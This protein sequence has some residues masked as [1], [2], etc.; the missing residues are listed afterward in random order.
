M[1]TIKYVYHHVQNDLYIH[2]K[3]NVN[4]HVLLTRSFVNRRL[5]VAT[6]SLPVIENKS[7]SMRFASECAFNSLVGMEAHDHQNMQF[8]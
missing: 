3:D 5:M 6:A 2:K 1:Q 7:P 4:E 8:F